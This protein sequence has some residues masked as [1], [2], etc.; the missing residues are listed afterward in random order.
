MRDSS[1]EVGQV[2][3]TDVLSVNGTLGA[4]PSIWTDTESMADWGHCSNGCC[5][6]LSK[7]MG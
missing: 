1:H 7:S 5:D 4:W 2:M 6:F 3:L